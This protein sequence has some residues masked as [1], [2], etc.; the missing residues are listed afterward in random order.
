MISL[1][2]ELQMLAWSVALGL[3]EI[4]LAVQAATV[5]RGIRWNFSS[6]ADE[7]PPLAGVAGRLDRAYKNFLETFPFF[8]AAVLLCHL[9]NRHDALTVW[10]V[11][12]YFWARVAHLILYA[13]DVVVVR[14]VIWL[15]SVIGILL[16]LI[17]LI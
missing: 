14:S 15:V 2:I 17:A 9:T 1:T 5:Q 8:L 7:L 12:L 10:G 11:Q 3:V 4:V 6:R 16:L 13:F